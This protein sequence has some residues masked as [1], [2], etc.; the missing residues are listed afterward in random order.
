[1]DQTSFSPQATSPSTIPPTPS[2]IGGSIKLAAAALGVVLIGGGL[3]FYFAN[4]YMS[5]G[6]DKGDVETLEREYQ[7]QARQELDTIGS[8]L[9]TTAVDGLDAEL[10]AIDRQMAK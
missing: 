2:R 1:M 9:S 6:A 8:D 4:F 5:D 10:S 3:Y 7:A